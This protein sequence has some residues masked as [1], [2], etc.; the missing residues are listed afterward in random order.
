MPRKIQ[1]TREEIIRAG[2]ELARER[3]MDAVNARAVAQRLGA[4]T[5]PLFREFASMEEIRGAVEQE[6]WALYGTY[7]HQKPESM[8][9][10]PYL[11]TGFQYIRFAREEPE[12]FRLLFM[13]DRERQ[14]RIKD[15]DDEN[16]EFVI[17]VAMEK[18][19]YSYELA[20]RLHGAIWIYAHGL[21][22]ML[23]TRYFAFTDAELLASLKEEYEALR[24]YYDQKSYQI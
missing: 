10:T 7:V 19:G 20:K 5:Q 3:G 13:C 4:S 12:L 1:F 16:Y 6:A 22:V 11:A 18:T 2:M 17:G 8:R 23:A 14:G 15:P 21:A 9:D 24:L